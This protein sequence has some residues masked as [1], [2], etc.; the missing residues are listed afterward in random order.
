MNAMQTL[1]QQLTARLADA[2]A[3]V[4]GR[5]AADIDPILRPV[6]D[7]NLEFGDFQS[8]GA[9]AL[10]K[11]ASM[12]PRQLA[13]QVVAA[14]NA[15]PAFL[16]ICE[17]AGPPAGPGFINLR[18][19]P[20]FV[21]STVASMAADSRLGVPKAAQPE[22]VVVDYS[23]PNIAKEMHIGHIRST[24]LGDA[25][26]R[27]LEFRGHQV[28]RQNHVGDWGTQFGMLIA[29][30]KDLL[31]TDPTGT[32]ADL[33]LNDLG[34]FY[35]Q[36]KMRF[37]ADPGFADAAREEVVSLQSADTAGLD[38]WGRFREISLR[39]CQAMYDRLGVLLTHSDVR[40]ESAY[41]AA[42]PGVVKALA[43]KGLLRESNGAQCVFLDQFKGEDG[44]PLP[45]IVQKTGGG[46]L[47]ATTDLAAVRYRVSELEANRILYV[48]DAR[49]SLHFQQIFAVARKAGFLP[50]DVTVVHVAFGTIQGADGKPMKTREGDLVSLREVLDEAEARA[51]GVVEQ[52]N[53][54]LAADAKQAVARV[55]GIG[56]IKYFD[57]SNN[58]M[59]DYRFD[60]DQ[61]LALTG[62]TAPYLQYAYARVRSIFR[63]G[64]VSDA[65]LAALSAVPALADPHEQALAKHLLGFSRAV[66]GVLDD[67]RPNIL[68]DYLYELARRF[69]GFFESCPVLKADEPTRSERLALCHL[70]AR[71]L[72]CGLDL[73]GIEVLDEM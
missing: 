55:V 18:L 47:Y 38:I 14:L 49:Q 35:R 66:L 63:K 30:L 5:P 72:R 28:I 60:W 54:D 26:V 57:L 67:Y 3:K 13:E 61:M 27:V 50:A 40:G 68:C 33:A 32:E 10:A 12:K 36:S 17:P 16:A 56:A 64:G 15:D 24:V 19:A 52:K 58:R 53:L 29:Y 8:N 46:Y 11:Q 51:L 73:L 69:S 43:D 4:L 59:S 21:R 31:L 1:D 65:D 23:C 41:N 2:F 6:G 71:V 7:A 20:E 34:A 39:H 70:T 45:V 25:L 44:Q 48:T 37:D 42:L 9:M 22:K 62:N